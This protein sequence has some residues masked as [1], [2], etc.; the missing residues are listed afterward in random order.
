MVEAFNE[1]TLMEVIDEIMQT[2]TI[3]HL[4][5]ED[6][7]MVIDLVADS[8]R[9]YKGKETSKF[10]EEMDEHYRKNLSDL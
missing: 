2:E 1:V 9:R 10:I 3:D 4:S 6:Q 8:I 5:I 7:M